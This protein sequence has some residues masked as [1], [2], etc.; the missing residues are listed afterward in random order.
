VRFEV[1]TA[2]KMM[3]FWVV[4]PC[5]LVGRYHRF[6]GMKMETVCFSET[7]VST[8]ESTR[9]H[10]P[11][12]QHHHCRGLSRNKLK[13]QNSVVNVSYLNSVIVTRPHFNASLQRELIARN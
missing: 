5:R 4:A 2:V 13:G 9:R 11:E 10:N 7:L 6:G 1:L 3:M 8:Y 12:Q